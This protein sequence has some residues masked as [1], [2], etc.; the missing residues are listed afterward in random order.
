MKR[1]T[2]TRLFAIV[3]MIVM[4]F[5]QTW[6]QTVNKPTITPG[7]K[8]S[9][10]NYTC[11]FDGSIGVTI[12]ADEGC[13]I[14]YKW[15]S[16]AS[17]SEALQISSTATHVDNNV[18]TTT[19]HYTISRVLSAIAVKTENGTTTYSEA[20]I[21]KFNYVADAKKTLTLTAS[22]FN[23]NIGVTEQIKVTAKDGDTEVTGLD[24]TYESDN[25]S[26]ATVDAN[27]VVKGIASGNCYITISFAGNNTYKDATTSINIGVNSA[28]TSYANGTIFTNIADVRHAG[29][30][31]PDGDKTTYK[32]VLDFTKGNTATVVGVLNVDDP[33]LG[34][35]ANSVFIVDNTGRG[36]W[37]PS[38]REENKTF[39]NNLKVGDVITGTLVGTFKQR[40]QLLPEFTRLDYKINGY[41]TKLNIK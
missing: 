30:L 26:I 15:G 27:G 40:T 34:E 20:T 17:T 6:A 24:Y 9:D 31:I 19:K 21:A 7:T 2:S 28:V 32:W 13:T 5:V 11:D 36:L 4:G 8:D 12:Q 39:I 10:G 41:S 1:F 35:G 3:C 37:I 14:I 38:S 29:Q 16:T 25:P 22:S 18:A 33:D 23:V